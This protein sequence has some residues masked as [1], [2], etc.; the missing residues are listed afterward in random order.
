MSDETINGVPAADVPACS[1]CEA[2]VDERIF[3]AYKE[4]VAICDQCAV[5]V[6]NQTVSTAYEINAGFVQQNEI[7]QALRR[8]ADEPRVILN[9]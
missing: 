5:A 9:D 1:F 2:S 6:V 3:M 7:I 4:K 8:K